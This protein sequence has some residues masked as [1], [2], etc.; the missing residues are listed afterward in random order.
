MRTRRLAVLPV[1]LLA[2][3]ALGACGNGDAVA[4]SK[5]ATAADRD[6]VL[7]TGGPSPAPS[8]TPTRATP[9]P[10]RQATPSPSTPDGVT[11]GLIKHASDTSLTYDK[12]DYDKRA[13]DALAPKQP[14]LV[15]VGFAACFS[16]VNPLTRTVPMSPKVEIL[17]IR[18]GD[19]PVGLAPDE[20]EVFLHSPSNTA[21]PQYS[22]FA[23][24]V[25]A[26]AVIRIEQFGVSHA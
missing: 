8:V 3:G 4:P 21:P 24:T 15:A 2:L 9:S 19:P 17:A 16:N 1:L 23:I 10:T 11:Y 14:V 18:E 22:S 5:P 7:T 25:A 13:C 6:E 26:G 20:L 12:I